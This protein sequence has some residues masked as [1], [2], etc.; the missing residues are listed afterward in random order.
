M[1]QTF[2]AYVTWDRVVPW[3]ILSLPEKRGQ[4]FF[5]VGYGAGKKMNVMRRVK[6]DDTIWVV[7]M[8][9]A[10]L[11]G[12]RNRRNFHPTL[13]AC[14]KVKSIC[15]GESCPAQLSHGIKALLKEWKSVAVSD[16]NESH[17]FELN[18]ASEALFR[19]GILPSM[20]PSSAD[21]EQ[22]SVLRGEVGRR[23]PK[24]L[25][26]KA[27]EQEAMSAFKSCMRQGS[28]KAV[29]ISYARIDGEE[30]A[31]EFADALLEKGF[32]PWLDSL[33][34]P[35]YN[36][37]REDEYDPPRL[38]KM[39]QLGIDRSAMAVCVITDEYRKKKDPFGMIWTQREW[40][41]IVRRYRRDP[42]FRIA[43]A[44]RAKR[45]V[46][47]GHFKLSAASTDKCARELKRWW[48]K[49]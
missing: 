48:E 25:R 36:V 17:F 4:N 21:E 39:L 46:C 49:G 9:R 12:K 38:K 26:L 11:K 32:S 44:M 40:D 16:P 7:T 13:V 15:P 19:L 6:P 28:K 33:A 18:D 47:K 1:S 10:K 43:C 3:K 24:I 27:S 22:V 35:R 14:I 30:F 8:P 31:L 45:S 34:I 5:P 2:L 42:G 20:P 29:F 37:K 41:R 23:I